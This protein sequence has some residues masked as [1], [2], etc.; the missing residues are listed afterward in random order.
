ML[1]IKGENRKSESLKVTPGYLVLKSLVPYK[2]KF[3]QIHLFFYS[4]SLCGLHAIPLGNVRLWSSAPCWAIPYLTC[5]SDQARC[6]TLIADAENPNTIFAKYAIFPPSPYF[7]EQ[8]MDMVHNLC[9]IRE[10]GG[11]CARFA[12]CCIMHGR[13]C[14]EHTGA[15]GG[16][17][18]TRERS[19]WR[20]YA[21]NVYYRL[22]VNFLQ[23]PWHLQ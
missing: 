6:L 13:G 23:R 7:D 11:F 2:Q 16:T 9:S 10:K 14:W 12:M 18:Q 5:Q 21:H 3:W 1:S 22:V 17:L 19:P 8:V 20:K 15:L 4:L